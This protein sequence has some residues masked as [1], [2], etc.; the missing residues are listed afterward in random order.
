MHL[1]SNKIIDV[2][3]AKALCRYI[4]KNIVTD[5]CMNV[6]DKCSNLKVDYMVLVQ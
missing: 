1:R 2:K 6:K 3:L 4:K 5:G